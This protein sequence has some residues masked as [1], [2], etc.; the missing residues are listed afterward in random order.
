MKIGMIYHF[1]N[2]KT[3]SQ[4]M[5]KQLNLNYNENYWYIL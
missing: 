3:L 1:L 5:A 4:E 2:E